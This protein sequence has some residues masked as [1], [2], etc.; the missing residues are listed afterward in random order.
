VRV[1]VGWAT[2]ADW[3]SSVVD[4]I[5]RETSHYLDPQ[6]SP[7][8]ARVAFTHDDGYSRSLGTRTI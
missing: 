4:R 6:P 5:A 8:L 3:G 2:G 7:T 1:G